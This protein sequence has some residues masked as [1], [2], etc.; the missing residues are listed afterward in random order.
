MTAQF[1]KKNVSNV[2]KKEMENVRKEFF[3]KQNNISK[4]TWGKITRNG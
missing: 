4:R 3:C 2:Q 1:P